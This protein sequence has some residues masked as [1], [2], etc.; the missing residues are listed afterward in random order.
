MNGKIVDAQYKL[1]TGDV[2][3]ILVDKNK[4]APSLDLT[5]F[6]RMAETRHRIRKAR[7]KNKI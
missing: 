4:K 5:K 1:R 7:K 2:V 6:A 3:E